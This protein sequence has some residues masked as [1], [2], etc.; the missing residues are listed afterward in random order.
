MA[1]G[2]FHRR[3]YEQGQGVF[4]VECQIRALPPP[5]THAL[6]TKYAGE[7]AMAPPGAASRSA[8]RR[9]CGR[10]RCRSA[11]PL[12]EDLGYDRVDIEAGLPRQ[13]PDAL[14][15]VQKPQWTGTAAM[16]VPVVTT[17]AV[18]LTVHSRGCRPRRS[19]GRSR[20]E[21]RIGHHQPDRRQE[22]ALEDH[23][24]R[25]AG[26]RQRWEW[27]VCSAGALVSNALGH[28]SA[29]DEADGP[30]DDGRC[31][32]NERAGSHPDEPR[33]R[34]PREPLGAARERRRLCDGVAGHEEYGDSGCER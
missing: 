33:V 13:F 12:L 18:P 22:P 6:T 15:G 14:L 28:D 10:R 17:V 19:R 2:R 24:A 1:A 5:C 16:T 20:I 27:T 7:T 3:H 25:V 26:R 34:Q 31:H 11:P 21:R 29:D 23:E 9:P 4:A 8:S 30:R 32:R